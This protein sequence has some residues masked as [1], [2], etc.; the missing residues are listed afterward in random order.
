[1]RTVPVMMLLLLLLMLAGLSGCDGEGI[2]IKNAV[3]SSGDDQPDDGDDD[4]DDGDTDEPDSIILGTW[5]TAYSDDYASSQARNGEHAH[6]AR[7]A[8][9]R[10][11]TAVTGQGVVYRI[12]SEGSP[13]TSKLNVRLS[14]TL[15]GSDLTL[16]ATS[17]TGATVYDV[18]SWVLRFAGRRMVGAY[19]A[20]NSSGDVVRS[21]HAV[22]YRAEDKALDGAWVTAFADAGGSS[23]LPPRPRTGLMVVDATGSD[24]VG[25]GTFVEQRENDVASELSFNVTTGEA[26]RPEFLFTLGEADLLNNE[27]DWYAMYTSGFMVGSY[28]QYT[29]SNTL[30]RFGQAMWVYSPPSIAPSA[31]TGRWTTAFADSDAAADTEFFDYLFTLDLR[32]LANNVVSGS[33]S[34]FQPLQDQAAFRDVT[35]TDAVVVGSRLQMEMTLDDVNEQLIWDLRVANSVMMGSYQ[36]LDS[37]GRYISRGSAQWRKE[38]T[39]PTLSGTWVG[40]WNDTATVSVRR[41]TQFGLMTVTGQSTAGVLTGL[42][43][44]R[45]ANGETS[46]RLFTMISS[47]VDGRDIEIIWRGTDLFGDT[48]WRLRQAGDNLFGVYENLNSAGN[49]ESV[50]NA[51]WVRTSQSNSF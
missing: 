36:H 49:V 44:L 9:T 38:S 3:V 4:D 22:W 39:T 27:M 21:G 43:A 29:A 19:V 7:I 15:S 12:M 50:G 40:A 10:E 46:R 26:D 5:I 34:Y 25:S 32:A 8:L 6:T 51:W 37:A 2:D 31:I 41:T 20:T 17:A 33:G 18:P 48:T 1:M 47:T 42:G 16:T 13:V 28:A 24:V 11:G 14:G 35:V 30:A 45:Y 23:S